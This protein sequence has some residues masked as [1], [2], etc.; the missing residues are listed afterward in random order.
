MARLMEWMADQVVALRIQLGP[1]VC[2][3]VILLFQGT[4]HRT[5]IYL[6]KGTHNY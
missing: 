5:H 2:A 4:R 6:Q 3:P 1:W